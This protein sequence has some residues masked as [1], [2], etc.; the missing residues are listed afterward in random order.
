MKVKA[1][2]KKWVRVIQGPTTAVF[3]YQ[4]EKLVTAVRIIHKEPKPVLF[5]KGRRLRNVEM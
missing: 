1:S 5:R 4:A 3:R 2:G